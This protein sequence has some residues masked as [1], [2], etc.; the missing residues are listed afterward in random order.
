[1]MEFSIQYILIAVF[2]MECLLGLTVNTIIV[3]ANFMKWKRLKSLQTCDKILSSLAICRGLNFIIILLE[4][5]FCI[6]FPWLVQN[7][8]EALLLK[9]LTMSLFNSSNWISTVLCVFYCVKI[10]NYNYKLF[11]FLKTRISTMVTPLILASLLISLLSTLPL[12]WHGFDVKQQ[13][14][15]NGSTENMTKYALLLVTNFD[16]YFLIFLVTSFPTFL[17]FCVAMFLLIN[18]L[19]KHTRQMRSNGSQIHNRNRES[20]LTALKSMTIFLILKIIIF[21]CMCLFTCGSSFHF[22]FP[23]L[24]G[25]IILFSPP[26]FH[27]LYVISS[28]CEVKKMF[29]LLYLGLIRCS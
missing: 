4:N 22:E 25:W 6:Y 13:N 21:I 5:F 8:I 19:L 16:Q 9:V 18:F 27:S 23:F 29:V 10:V 1:M 17:I 24:I 11:V 15:L 14:I 12:G 26:L 2:S 7:N 3:V 20:Q 28:S